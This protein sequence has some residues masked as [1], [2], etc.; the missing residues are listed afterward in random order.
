MIFFKQHGHAQAA[1]FSDGSKAVLRVPSESGNRFHKDAVNFPLSAVS[2]HPLK[3]LS[4]VHASSGQTL[5]GIDV[6][7]MPIL[8]LT[9]HLR[10]GTDLS[11]VGMQLIRRI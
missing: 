4:L 6:H 1:E 5:I 7:Q 8:V 2:H 9:D 3:F 10:V 11:G